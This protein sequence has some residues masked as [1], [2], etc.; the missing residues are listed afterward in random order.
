MRKKNTYSDEY[1]SAFIDGELESEERARLL[2]DEE[3]DESLAQRINETRMLKEKV[4]LTYADIGGRRVENK[5]FSC[6]AFV[7]RHRAL[8]ASFV[9]LSMA[10]MMFVY[11]VSDD[12]NLIIARQLIN[13]TEPL[14]VSSIDDAVGDNQHVV[15]NV[16]QYDPKSFS[17]T[18]DAIEALLDSRKKSSFELEVVANAQGV[19]VLDAETSR[20]AD[21]LSLLASRFDNF[22]VV[23]C[24]KSLAE[25]AAAGDPIQLMRSIMI[26]PS[27]AEQVARR[28][29]AGWLYLKI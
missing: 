9:L 4:Q 20:H 10:A 28:T 29:A 15:I 22:E 6:A 23:A 26:T 3:K 2:F 25:L 14:P 13:S 19:K 12:D 8:A 27:A 24:A 16:S 21:Q 1:I 18:I 11:D 7:S 17:E 5:P